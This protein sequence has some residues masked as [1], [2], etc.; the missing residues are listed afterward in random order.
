[1]SRYET[2]CKKASVAPC[3][4][5]RPKM[6]C[7]LAIKH[8]ASS[9]MPQQQFDGDGAVVLGVRR[10]SGSFKLEKPL[11]PCMV[12]IAVLDAEAF[13]KRNT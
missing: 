6:A 2:A 12:L 3:A 1:M 8:T 9:M 4:C 11:Q 10:V 5:P 13:S 7:L